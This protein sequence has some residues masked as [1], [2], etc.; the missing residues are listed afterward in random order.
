MAKTPNLLLE[1]PERSRLEPTRIDPLSQVFLAMRVKNSDCV[2]LE[3]AGAWGFRFAGYDHAH[4]GVISQGSCWLSLDESGKSVCLGPGDCWL[5]PQG[6][7]HALRDQPSTPLRPYQEIQQKKTH[8]VVRCG[9]GTNP[10]TIIVGNFTFDGQSGKWLTDILPELI[11]F[12][13]DQFR[14]DQ[15]NSLAM[16]TILQL[17][18]LESQTESMGATVVVSRLADILF[19]QAVRAYVEQAGPRA[20]GWLKAIGDRQLRFALGAMHEAVERR[21]T[22]GSLASSAAMSRS[23]FAA[24]FKDLVGESPLEYLTRWRVYKAT[25]LLRETDLKVAKIASLVGYESDAAFNRTF[26]KSVG[27]APGEYRRSLAS[28]IFRSAAV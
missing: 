3:F 10:T 25:Q 1:R 23:G 13:M 11:Q 5:L 6:H 22:V 14:R 27:Q 28:K 9:R 7:T 20:A 8:G 26:K 17:L 16:H 12:R 15:G 2:R 21:W 18:A 24:R 19:V 4:F